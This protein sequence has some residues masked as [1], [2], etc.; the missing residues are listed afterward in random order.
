MV[1]ESVKQAADVKHRDLAC[2]NLQLRPC[3]GFEEF[4]QCAITTG[5]GDVGVCQAV[6]QCFPFVHVDGDSHVGDAFMHEFG[7]C[8]MSGND[9]DDLAAVPHDG[10]CEN[11]HDARAAAAVNQCVT[12]LSEERSKEFSRFRELWQISRS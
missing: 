7:A 1:D 6:H 11:P 5:Q 4:F 2:V 3:D 8:Q 12:V 10:V 9:S